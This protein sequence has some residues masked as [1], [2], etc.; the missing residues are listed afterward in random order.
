MKGSVSPSA[1]SAPKVDAVVKV[2]TLLDL[3]PLLL[4]LS[5]DREGA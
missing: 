5:L 2:L 4:T 1:C 3:F